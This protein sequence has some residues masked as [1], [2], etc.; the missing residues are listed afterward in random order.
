MS[1]FQYQNH[2]SKKTGPIEWNGVFLLFLSLLMAASL[3]APSLAGRIGELIHRLLLRLGGGS[4]FLIPAYFGWLGLNQLRKEKRWIKLKDSLFFLSLFLSVA[5]ILSFLPKTEGAELIGPGG[6]IGTQLHMILV[7]QFGV[8]LTFAGALAVSACSILFLARISPMS[9]IALLKEKVSEDIR[10]WRAE[11]KKLEEKRNLQKKLEQ[12]SPQTAS[13]ENTTP[14]FENKLPNINLKEPVPAAPVPPQKRTPKENGVP[15]TQESSDKDEN[16]AAYRSPD[17]EILTT[18]PFQKT[19]ISRDA[20]YANGSLLEKTLEQF[21]VQAKVIDI[22][23]GPVVTRYDL[24]P[25]PGVRVQ[26]IET[27]SND[28]ALVMKA[29]SL[30]VLAPVPGKAAVGI[31]ISN[32]NPATVSL[33]EML[34]SQQFLNSR[35]HIPLGIG[36]TAEGE[37]YVSDLTTMPHLLIA[38]ATG[39]GKSVCIHGLI[40]SILFRFRP[41][42][43]KLLLI[44][45]KRLE[46]PLYDGIPHLFDPAVP[47]EEVRVITS[48]KDTVRSLKK[49]V[50][51]MELRYESFA[52]M[53]V[54]NIEGYNEKAVKENVPKV[55]Y[56]LIVIDELADLMITVGKEIEDLIQRLAQMARAVGIHL[57]LATQRPSVDVITGVI[58]ANLPSR[59]AFQVLSK[60]DSR[61]ILDSQGAENLLG[62]GDMLFLNSGA[63]KPIR[64]QGAFVSEKDV[65]SVV[66]AIKSQ[67][68]HPRYDFLLS[69]PSGDSIVDS[70]ENR[71]L[72][73]RAAKVVRDTEKVSGDLLRADKEIG[74]KYD[75]ALTL[76]KK[77]GLIEKPPDTN[78]WK[79]HFDRLGEF[80][81]AEKKS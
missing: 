64:V 38:G 40:L 54:R 21:D 43:V 39:S 63:P 22:H 46:L 10:E 2:K 6:W 16:Y 35:Y 80:L 60:T 9:L 47:A 41:D 55:P 24:T 8:L 33:K 57:V 37:S 15:P 29:Q 44:D 61:V 75:W 32:P 28:I 42:E 72:L 56:L 17:P 73:V 7:H 45:P 1:Q 27:L 70:E 65:E 5:V 81:D 66:Q 3:L 78:R 48:P 14:K 18:A 76:L 53:G 11:R 49:L 31:E 52:K 25:A 19:E 77:K 79:I 69:N 58:K 30:R 13:A 20:L 71:Q 36:R 4:S 59:I 67:G 12:K 68:F 74:S 50:E 51:V 34:S 26:Q 23:P 62:R